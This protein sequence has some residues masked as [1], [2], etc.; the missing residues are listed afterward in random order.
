MQAPPQEITDIPTDNDD[1]KINHRHTRNQV[2]FLKTWF[3]S[4]GDDVLLVSF[5]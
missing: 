2:F 5:Q 1:R 3:L 4:S